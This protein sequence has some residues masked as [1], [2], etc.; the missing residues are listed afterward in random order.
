MFLYYRPVSTETRFV[1]IPTF[2]II[3]EYNFVD[4]SNVVVNISKIFRI[5]FSVLVNRIVIRNFLE[6][7]IPNTGLNVIPVSIQV[8]GIIND[9]S[10]ELK[11]LMINI[12]RI[13]EFLPFFLVH[14][15]VME[16]SFVDFLLF[17]VSNI[18]LF[19][20]IVCEETNV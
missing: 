10:I 12:D 5:T 7:S 14:F 19:K 20:K 18:F 17:K 9:H 13:G 4:V 1:T 16:N 3:S 2:D 6:S 8:F 11:C 15:I